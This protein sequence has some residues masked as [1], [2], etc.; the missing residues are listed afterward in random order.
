[1]SQRDI[2]QSLSRYDMMLY[3]LSLHATNVHEQQHGRWCLSHTH[4]SHSL[5]MQSLWGETT[6]V[7]SQTDRPDG[8]SGGGGCRGDGAAIGP[9]L[10]GGAQEQGYQLRQQL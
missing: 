6:R 8:V 5:G 9:P 7:N 3:W 10:V 1:M 4:V 2:C